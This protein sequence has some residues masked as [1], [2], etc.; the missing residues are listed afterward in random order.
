MKDFN[1]RLFV[2]ISII[3]G[4]LVVMSLFSTLEKDSG[5]VG[6]NFLMVLLSGLFAVLRF[7]VHTV[8][9]EMAETSTLVFCAGLIIN[10]LFY[11]FIIER[12]CTKVLRRRRRENTGG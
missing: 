12:F 8:L 4:L 10:C 1:R 9:G 6:S 5:Q 3:A 2:T 7:P 11:A